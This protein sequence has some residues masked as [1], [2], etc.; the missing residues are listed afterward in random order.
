M[1]KW[2]SIAGG[3]F[4]QILDA[5]KFLKENSKKRNFVQSFDLIINLKN[6]DL[7]KP[8]NR[9]SKEVVLPHICKETSVCIISDSIKDENAITKNDILE[10]ERDKKKAKQFITKY[11][12][13]LCEAPL[14]PLVGKILGRYLGPK[15]KMPKLFL[16]GR[17]E[18]SIEETKRSVRI[19]IKDSPVIQCIIG[20]EDMNDNQL[21]ENI[22]TVIDAVKK[23]LPAKVQIKNILLK[24]T[25]SKAVKLDV[26]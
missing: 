26:K 14:M 10:F 18:Q 12:F 11:D 24:L 8:E 19:R 3:F 2:F 4:M 5:I 13:F 25:M 22:E 17:L 23:A 16:P 1:A 21:V 9:I 6:I 20:K 15:G 7:K